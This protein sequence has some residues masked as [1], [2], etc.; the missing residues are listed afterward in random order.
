[1]NPTH[2][3]PRSALPQ[4]TPHLP[5][6]VH[7]LGAG[8]AGVS[9]A[10]LLL[11]AAGHRVSASDR[12]E[13]EHTRMLRAAGIDVRVGDEDQHLPEGVGLLVRSAAVPESDARV[14]EAQERGVPVL[15]YSELLGRIT[16]AGRTLAVA[17]THGKTTT[18]WM[19]QHALRGL[20]DTLRVD[21]A[22]RA[23]RPDAPRPGALPAPG[24]LIGGVCREQGVNALRQESGGWFAVEACE[25]DRSFLQL[26]PAGAVI[27]NVE[28]DHLDYFGDL[29]A[30]KGAFARFADRVHPDGLLAVGPE[31]PR[32]VE[33]GA[34]CPVWRLGRDL[35]VQLLSERAGC[36]SFRLRG[37]EFTVEE[38][39]LAVPGR[40]NVDNAAL[41]I[42]LCVG[43]AAR[44]WCLD[45][46]A[47]AH[48]AARGLERFRGSQRRFEPWG[49]V[50]GVSV[51]HDYAHHPTEV[52]VTLEAARRAL[53]GRPL[54][55]LFQ[56][57][58]YSRT[59]RFLREF[60]ESLAFADRVTVA[61]VYGARAHIDGETSAGAEE[62]VDQ[63]R[64]LGVDAHTGGPLRT[65]V[66][67]FVGGLP[68]PCAALVLG[69]GDVGGIR[70]ELLGEL[71]LSRALESRSRA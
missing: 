27:T 43:L 4:R 55:V 21:E 52:R 3:Q 11:R 49:E 9:G 57:H 26:A 69:A 1:M 68:T 16:P 42:A 22:A 31:L 10:A 13:S 40:F 17:G 53:P 37:P 46:E 19:L 24:A 41:A 67:R 28:A 12:A 70:D 51:V 30:I 62:L 50:G 6:R 48:A 64:A 66:K 35:K 44:E 65:A 45:P 36:F 15:K 14:R 29:D 54:H 71:A 34:R 20:C 61:E 18:S 58:Q 59:A 8:G 39:R 25:Y 56:P 2:P 38:L 32:R 23:R 7:L 60:A 63:A 33:A 47:A 5:E